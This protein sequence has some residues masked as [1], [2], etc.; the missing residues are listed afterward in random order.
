ML[1]GLSIRGKLKVPKAE[2]LNRRFK[3]SMNIQ[4]MPES[5]VSTIVCFQQQILQ[6]TQTH[7]AIVAPAISASNH[8]SKPAIISALLSGDVYNTEPADSAAICDTESSDDLDESIAS[9][10]SAQAESHLQLATLLSNSSTSRQWSAVG[11][12]HAP[13]SEQSYTQ[14]H[15]QTFRSIICGPAVGTSDSTTFTSISDSFSISG[16]LLASHDTTAPTSEVLEVE[17]AAEIEDEIKLE[18]EPL[19]LQLQ[20]L[21]AL[22]HAQRLRQI[23][24]QVCTLN[25]SCALFD[26]LY[27]RL[28]S[29]YIIR[30]LLPILN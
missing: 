10:W 5:G 14:H 21:A 22:P 3:N 28:L 24:A 9:D 1:P 12:I 17:E 4:I 16:L 27:C 29:Q 20:S 19:S 15:A 13:Q 25:T 8:T 11:A 6:C 30:I 18:N 7:S 23:E 26:V 2:L